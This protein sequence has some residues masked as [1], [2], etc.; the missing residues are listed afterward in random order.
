MAAV[1]MM[2]HA[3]SGLCKLP[4]RRVV[5]RWAAVPRFATV[6]MASQPTVNYA[7]ETKH[8]C[9]QPACLVINCKMKSADVYLERSVPLPRPQPEKHT[10]RQEKRGQMPRK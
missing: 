1:N 8:I 10:P 5:R 4:S 9:A 2:Y 7:L 6:E 3:A